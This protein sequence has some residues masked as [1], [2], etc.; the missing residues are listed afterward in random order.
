MT[1]PASPRTVDQPGSPAGPSRGAHLN[2]TGYCSLVAQSAID[3]NQSPLFAKYAPSAGRR[4]LCSELFQLNAFGLGPV[5]F[6]TR[7]LSFGSSP[8]ADVISRT[9]ARLA[10]SATDR[11]ESRVEA[12]GWSLYSLVSVGVPPPD[13][14]RWLLLAATTRCLQDRERSMCTL[15]PCRWCYLCSPPTPNTG[16][17][18]TSTPPTRPLGTPVTPQP[19]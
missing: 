13:S 14:P 15:A 9:A 18:T 5:L 12:N 6:R 16:S 7:P 19:A 2:M 8:F 3:A 10:T 17:L 4:W 11:P 1:V